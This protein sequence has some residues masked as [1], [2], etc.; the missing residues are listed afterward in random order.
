MTTSS[1]IT[2]LLIVGFVWGGFS[3][4]LLTAIRKESGKGSEG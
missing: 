3:M 4:V 2:M 1:W